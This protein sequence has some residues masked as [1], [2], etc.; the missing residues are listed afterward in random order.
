MLDFQFTG[1]NS[2]FWNLENV[3]SP[4]GTLRKQRTEGGPIVFTSVLFFV[5]GTYFDTSVSE[6]NIRLFEI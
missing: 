4:E 5:P 3:L 6:A 2:P 1:E